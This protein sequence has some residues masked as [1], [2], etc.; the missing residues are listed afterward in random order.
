MTD[1]VQERRQKRLDL[2]ERLTAENENMRLDI[3][4]RTRRAQDPLRLRH[5]DAWPAPERAKQA[6]RQNGSLL[7]RDMP[8]KAEDDRG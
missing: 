7:Y 8:S 4:A 2:I 5:I 3:E 1:S 6:A